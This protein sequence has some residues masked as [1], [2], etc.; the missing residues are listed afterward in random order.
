M[1]ELRYLDMRMDEIFESQEEADDFM[2][3]YFGVVKRIFD[4]ENS[5]DIGANVLFL[6]VEHYINNRKVYRRFDTLFERMKTDSLKL[7]N[8]DTNEDIHTD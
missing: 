8:E 7:E 5:E 1:P 6:V 2:N 4:M 3:S